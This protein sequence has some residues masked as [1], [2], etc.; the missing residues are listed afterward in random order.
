MSQLP[1]TL[2]HPPTFAFAGR[3][4]EF[5]LLRGLLPRLAGEGRRVA[6][7]SGE[8]GAGKTRLTREL[9]SEL[10]GEGVT[11]LYGAC[12]AAVRVPYR[13]FLE[14]L[15]QLTRHWSEAELDELQRS[16]LSRLLPHRATAAEHS[17]PAGD[18]DTER[19]RLHVAVAELL[20]AASERSPLLLVLDD[21]HWADIPTLLLLRHLARAAADV[22]M[23]LIVTYRDVG[24]DASGQLNETLV[25]VRRSEGV[26]GVRLSRLSAGEIR[27]FAR[28]NAGVE[29]EPALATEI[30][31]LTE[32]N[33]FLVTEMWRELLETG[34]LED[35]GGLLRL[36]RSVDS[37]AT[38][39]SV[40]AMVSQRL[41]R[42]SPATTAALETAAIAGAEF[43]LAT[44]RAAADLPE[45]EL[46]DSI[47]EAA[48]NG[49]ISELPSRGLSYRFGH[50]L[51]R[52]AVTDRLSAR[53]RAE[54]H[55]RVA[56]ALAATP[57]RE[58]RAGQLAALAHHFAAAA[59]LGGSERA[60]RYN[61]LAARA[62][63]AALAYDD[64]A[65]RLR[66]ALDLGISDTAEAAS[67]QLDLGYVSHRAGNAIDALD[68]F[69][70]T[71]ELAR[72]L[73]DA[74]LL[75]RAAVGFEEACW[76]PGMH[77]VE[78]VS[79]LQEAAAAL[80][81]EDSE[82][83]TRVLGSLARALDLRG[84]PAAAA[85]AAEQ[86]M[87]MARRRGDQRGLARTLAGAWSRGSS[88]DEENNALLTEALQIGEELGDAELCTE[89]I[90]WLIPSYVS[91]CDHDRARRYLQRLFDGARAQN[92]P[93]HL[94]VAE[95]YASALALCDGDL[96][97]AEAAATRSWEWSR[98]LT[99]RDATGAYGLQMFN[100]RRE[101]SRL[102]ELL[103][104]VRLLAGASATAWR[105]GMSALLAE[106][107]MVGEARS[108][109][110]EA[111]FAELDEQRRSLWS[112]SLAYLT[113]TTMLLADAEAA[114]ALYPALAG[115][116]GQNTVVGHLVACFGAV[117]R[118]LG[119]LAAVLG[120][121]ERGEEHFEAAAA[122]NHRLGAHTWSAHTAGE[123]GRMLLARGRPR[124][125]DRAGSLLRE[126]LRLA[127]RFGLVRVAD[128]ARASGASV[129][130]EA[131]RLAGLT[132]READVLRLVAQGL[133]NREIGRALFISEHTTASHVRSILRKTDCA[134]R[135]EAAAY[136]HR[137]GLAD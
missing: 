98:L 3:V 30:A 129:I 24:E 103:P 108:E 31:A 91:L 47:D 131:T 109:L 107:G 122:L 49:L 6:L 15:D 60:I 74:E 88:S 86:S 77:D 33:P 18:P 35:S 45:P 130:P 123:H 135:T 36:G 100:I 58:E 48:R 117:D 23:L 7:I 132:S 69:R 136:A 93:F 119:M 85:R 39:E 40:R 17:A 134:N 61:L 11:V 70:R 83:L 112:A 125:R 89:A 55:L 52:L 73:G 104:V 2:R 118:Y 43:E 82:L 78:S 94:H 62:A 16:Q 53:R 25:E 26:T 115:Y 1:G 128:R 124:E 114:A 9:A 22:R 46:L 19:H 4:R 51:V 20:A 28:A 5:E 110:H 96:S 75:A 42:L 41:E 76:R 50:E 120:E 64:A 44:L 80:G 63:A 12:D 102:A 27:D 92:Q 113:D 99:G 97:E 57:G 14:V 68:A 137:R 59:P 38:P 127:G 106:L 66:T 72:G 101:Q 32:G 56:E 95:H 105:P 65:E 8:P 37:V 67:V 90:G 121:W 87:A 21:L 79:L 10:A 81:R 13:P 126:S 116:R 111:V 71:A 34:S 84:E 133:S 29:P 54:V